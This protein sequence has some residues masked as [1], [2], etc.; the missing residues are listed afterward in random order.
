MAKDRV[1]DEVIYPYL[2]GRE[3]LTGSGKPGRF[4]IDFDQMSILDAQRCEGA[5]DHVRKTVLPALERKAHEE[6]TTER[7]HK[8]QMERW[9]LHWRPRRELVQAISRI[10]RFMVCSRVTKRPIFV[11]VDAHVRPGDAIQAFPFEDDYS[12]GVL[13]SDCHWRWFVAKCSKLTERFRYTPESVFDTF[14]W[15][16]SPGVKQVNAVANAG[17][18]VRRVRAE[19]LTKVRGGL[20]AVYR[21]LELPGKNPLKDAHAALDAAVLDAY[22]FSPRKDLLAQLLA[23]NL[24]VARRID[25]GEP[26]TAPGVPPDYPNPA[27]LITADCVRA[28]E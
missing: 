10:R 12:F 13:Q 23:L 7:A 22:G 14:P 16:Q 11:F 17:R 21:T 18:E 1:S 24:A 9:W 19:A 26:V 5:F 8:D 2:I 15:P 4:V 27:R 20:R 28:D 25:A 6:H 3:L